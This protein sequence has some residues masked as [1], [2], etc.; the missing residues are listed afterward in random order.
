MNV[1][2]TQFNLLTLNT[3]S[4]VARDPGTSTLEN[5]MVTGGGDLHQYQSA[6]VINIMRENMTPRT[7][8]VTSGATIVPILIVPPT[9]NKSNNLDIENTDVLTLIPG[10]IFIRFRVPSTTTV[11]LPLLAVTIKQYSA[12]LL[13][14]SIGDVDREL[15]GPVLLLL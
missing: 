13:S 10:P 9:R 8:I 7:I 4:I 3:L 5:L 1:E 6:H 11:T 2:H 15:L 14:R 12:M